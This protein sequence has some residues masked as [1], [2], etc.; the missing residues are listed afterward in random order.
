M[1]QSRG[2]EA[3][4]L[5]WRSSF[6]I[7][8]RHVLIEHLRENP[9]IIGKL[10]LNRPDLS[11][12]LR[13][14]RGADGSAAER[15]MLAVELVVNSPA[16]A[17]AFEQVF[18]TLAGLA[19]ADRLR[20]VALTGLA[21]LFDY[22]GRTVRDL[23][24]RGALERRANTAVAICLGGRASLLYHALL[25]G[26]EEQELALAFFTQ[27]TGEAMP[28]ARLVFSEAPKQ[29]VAY[30]LVRDDSSLRRSGP[31]EPILGEAVRSGGTEVPA[32]QPVSQLDPD[33]MWR[34]ENPEEFRRFVKKLP[35]MR[36]P[37]RGDGNHSGRVDW[38]G[39]C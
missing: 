25:P 5:V 17:V 24:E 28:R 13:S 27:A 33:Q 7:A 14:L 26:E 10:A 8:G 39:Q 1:V 22:V 9:E 21:G 19:A 32:M 38:A 30:G 36:N 11:D 2:L 15:R 29:E 37:R 31:A 23:A 6:Q 12:L 35:E 34:I 4:R 20:A 3:E 18:P 16:F